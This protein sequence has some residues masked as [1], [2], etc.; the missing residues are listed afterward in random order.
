MRLVKGLLAAVTLFMFSSVMADAQH[1]TGAGSSFIYPAMA[2]W[3][4]KYYEKTTVE[5]NYQPMGSG[6]GV[7]AIET[8]TV[9]F[10]ATDEPLL[11]T[12]L[13]K[14]HLLQ[15]PMLIGG[16]V[17]VIHLGGAK[18]N[19]VVLNG[20]ALADIYL[21][22]ITYWDD[23]ILV[24]LNPKIQLPHRM[25]ITVHRADGSGTTFNFTSYLS[26]VSPAW[27]K[28]IG[29]ATLVAWP[30]NGIGAQG[31]AGVASQVENLPYSIGYVEYAYA[32]Q[33]QMVTTQMQNRSGKTVA[34]SAETF[35]AAASNARWHADQGFYQILV[36]QPGVKSWPIVAT[37]F[38]LV[39]EKPTSVA[40][41]NSALQFLTWAYQNGA[42]FVSS[43]D[44]VSIPAVVYQQVFK[45]WQPLL[46]Q[47]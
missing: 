27:Q 2:V 5:V 33:N 12:E 10:A 15:A 29:A 35:V 44:Y 24:K 39:A 6:G 32:I 13:T 18:P 11:Q 17:P 43:L 40:E 31:N 7:R 19:D 45:Q 4:Q 20:T 46:Q 9:A 30:G 25:I 38:V 22:V 36:N 47:K 41:R 42:P 8:G 23:P 14:R 28:K 26:S 16:I 21:G 34:P 37:T 3:A 1:V